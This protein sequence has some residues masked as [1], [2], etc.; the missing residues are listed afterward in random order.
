MIHSHPGLRYVITN[1]DTN[2]RSEDLNEVF[3]GAESRLRMES[4]IGQ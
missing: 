1:V 2:Q 3:R 4:Y